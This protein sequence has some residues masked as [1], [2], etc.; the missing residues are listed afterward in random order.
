MQDLLNSSL[1]FPIITSVNG[2]MTLRAL[3][4]AKNKPSEPVGASEAVHDSCLGL[5]KTSPS[6]MNTCHKQAPK[7]LGARA[8]KI[9][10]VAIIHMPGNTIEKSSLPLVNAPTNGG[11]IRQPIRFML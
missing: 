8:T 11:N 1:I 3:A 5:H 7:V 9:G 10:D 4:T 2:P 6:V